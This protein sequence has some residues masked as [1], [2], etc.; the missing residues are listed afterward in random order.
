MN[1]DGD[2]SAYVSA[3]WN[4]LV[5]SAIVLGCTVEEAHDLTQTTLVKCYIA[6]GKVQRAANPDAY[7][8]K[9]LLNAHR[10]SRRR[11]WWGEQPTETLPD[12]TVPDPTAGVDVTD[13]L[14]RALGDLSEVNREVVVLRYY[15]N[16]SEQQ[17]ADVLGVAPGTVKSRLA[18]ALQQL[19]TNPHLSDLPEGQPS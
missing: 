11:R 6:W 7:V 5:R 4:A 12:R 13:A 1:A 15:A 16:L 14:H 3:R 9:M 10:D 17:T 8:Y 2:F 19:G 18:R